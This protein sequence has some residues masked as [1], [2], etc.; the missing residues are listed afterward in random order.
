[1]GAPVESQASTCRKVRAV[2]RLQID[3]ASDAHGS[4]FKAQLVPSG[5]V[6]GTAR[7]RASAVRRSRMPKQ[8]GATPI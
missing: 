7:R 2:R 4:C 3:D 1:M 6:Q 5:G 8:H